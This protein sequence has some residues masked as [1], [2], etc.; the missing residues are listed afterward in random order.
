[1]A[2]VLHLSLPV[3][4]LD[5]TRRFYEEVLGC[6]VGRVR[7]DW[8]DMWFF[9]LQLTL[10]RDPEHVVPAS[11]QGVRHF[12]VALQRD[13]F[14]QLLRRLRD[15]EVEWLGS[16]RPSDSELLS[17]KTAVKVSDPSGNVIE[18][19]HYDDPRQVIG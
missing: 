9:G 5:D 4:D 6:R 7:E 17:G 13:E 8:L 16:T 12:G 18:F 2:P 11:E 3:A 15:H 1:M 14:E 19:K 10:Q